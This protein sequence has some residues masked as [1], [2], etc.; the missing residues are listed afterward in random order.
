MP[1][2]TSVTTAHP[3]S[4]RISMMGSS[5]SVRVADCLRA[6][7]GSLKE[8]RIALFQFYR[9]LENLSTNFLRVAQGR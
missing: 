1:A 3:F 7:G 8:L 9:Q 6:I 4:Q 2:T 5:A